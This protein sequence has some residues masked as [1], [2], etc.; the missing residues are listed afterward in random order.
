MFCNADKCDD[1]CPAYVI[2]YDN[3]RTECKIINAQ[4]EAEEAKKALYQAM[5]A[6]VIDTPERSPCQ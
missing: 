1:K 3:E 6:R 5:K 2:N 4:L